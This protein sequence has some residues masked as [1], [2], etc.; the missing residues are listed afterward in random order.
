MDTDTAS[1]GSKSEPGVAEEETEHCE[2]CADHHGRIAAIE[3]HL[4]INQ[5]EDTRTEGEKRHGERQ[6]RDERL[7]RR[8]RR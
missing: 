4:G 5:P 1:L 3:A 8:K 2:H 6:A 7:A